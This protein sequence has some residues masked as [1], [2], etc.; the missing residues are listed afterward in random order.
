MLRPRVISIKHFNEI[1][2]YKFR[3]YRLSFLRIASNVLT[4][5]KARITVCEPLTCDNLYIRPHRS[6]MCQLELLSK[7]LLY[8]ED[9][10]YNFVFSIRS[11]LS[12]KSNLIFSFFSCA[13]FMT[14]D[15][16]ITVRLTITFHNS[17]NKYRYV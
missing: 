2:I 1:H 16:L 11:R 5:S 7:L 12:I 17:C 13:I 9:V 10:S 6:A 15:I 4:Q 8:L 3:H 14:L